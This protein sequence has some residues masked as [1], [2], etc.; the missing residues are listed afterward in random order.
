VGDP[1]PDVTLRT[2]TGELVRLRD[3]VG[4]RHLVIFF[5]P[6]DGSPICTAEACSFRDSYGALRGLDADVVGISRDDG[7]AHTAFAARH[8]LQFPLLSD[9]EGT[10]RRAFGV[11]PTMGLLPGR[12][13][14]VIDKSGVVRHVFSSAL[15]S[16]RHVREAL[17]A[18]H[19]LNRG[20]EDAATGRNSGSNPNARKCEAHSD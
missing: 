3:Y 6:K 4:R 14:Y 20:Q 5:Y 19:A 16:A 12:A 8:G 11:K 2:H 10:A 17:A 18:L 15:H 9:P 13:T 1:L 7:R